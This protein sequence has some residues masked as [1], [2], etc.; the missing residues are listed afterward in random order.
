MRRSKSWLVAG[1]M[2]LLVVGMAAL[3]AAQDDAPK[4]EM[5]GGWNYMGLQIGE[6]DDVGASSTRAGSARLR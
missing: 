6:S 3:S 1:V 2:S 5:A 4:V